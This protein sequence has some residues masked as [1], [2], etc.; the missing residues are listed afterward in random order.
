[1][2]YRIPSYIPWLGGSGDYADEPNGPPALVIRDL[3]PAKHTF[4]ERPSDDLSSG[5]LDGLPTELIQTV[6][7]YLDFKSRVQL[8]AASFRF[9]PETNVKR[10]FRL[11]SVM[12]AKQ[13]AIDVHGSMEALEALEALEPVTLPRNPYPRLAMAHRNMDRRRDTPL[14][15]PYLPKNTMDDQ[16]SRARRISWRGGRAVPTPHRRG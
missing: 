6:L 15:R 10:T 13:L 16:A 8:C 12:Q 11:V 7:E 14:E 4:I 9:R 5:H 2:T 1:M 3:K